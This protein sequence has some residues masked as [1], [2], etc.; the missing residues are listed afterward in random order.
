MVCGVPGDD[1]DGRTLSH[2]SLALRAAMKRTCYERMYCGK[3]G[4]LDVKG[5]MDVW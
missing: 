5:R 4:A 3:F 2:G 1:Y